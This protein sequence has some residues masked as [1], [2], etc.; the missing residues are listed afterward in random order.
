MYYSMNVLY[1]TSTENIKH[2]LT[3]YDPPSA[4]RGRC[5]LGARR[6]DACRNSHVYI[7]MYIYIYIYIHMYTYNIYIE[8]ERCIYV[9]TWRGSP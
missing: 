8:R 9:Y 5:R 3:V 7:Y 6:S 1:Y 2:S 4:A